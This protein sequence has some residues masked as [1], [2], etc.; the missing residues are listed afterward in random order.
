MS[1][2]ISFLLGALIMW[3][4]LAV[5]IVF[6]EIHTDGVLWPDLAAGI[7]V[8]PILPVLFLIKLVRDKSKG[9]K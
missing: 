8:L 7:A 3:I 6:L 4:A 2:V 1:G 5:Y 9:H